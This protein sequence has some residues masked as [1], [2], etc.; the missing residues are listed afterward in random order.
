MEPVAVWKRAPV[1]FAI[2]LLVVGAAVGFGV[3]YKVG[4][5][6][7]STAAKT[8]GTAARKLTPAQAQSQAKYGRLLTCMANHGVKWPKPPRGKRVD[9]NK[10]PPGVSKAKYNTELVVCYGAALT[11]PTTK[12]TAR[13]TGP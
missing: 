6:G 1:A 4:D 2:V 11:R 10:A 8:P 13:A 3:G 7:N 9:F 5:S 12:T